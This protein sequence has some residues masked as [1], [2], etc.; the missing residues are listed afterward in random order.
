MLMIK[1][2]NLKLGNTIMNNLNIRFDT[3][4]K[5]ALFFPRILIKKKQILVCTLK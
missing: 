2:E 1:C 3:P 4:V 5:N